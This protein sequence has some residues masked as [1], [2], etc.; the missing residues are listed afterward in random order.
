MSGSFAQELFLFGKQRPIIGTACGYARLSFS[1]AR[2]AETVVCHAI[3]SGLL[4]R[5]EAEADNRFVS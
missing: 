2:Q 4:V 3:L 5:A 1:R